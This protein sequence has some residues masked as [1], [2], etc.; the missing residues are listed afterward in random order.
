[1]W[2]WKYGPIKA[3]GTD[4]LTGTPIGIINLEIAA[5]IVQMTCVRL[6]NRG[7]PIGRIA[8][9]LYRQTFFGAMLVPLTEIYSCA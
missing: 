9:A 6:L 4:S 1:L 5:P 2:L 3:A 7:F 8:A